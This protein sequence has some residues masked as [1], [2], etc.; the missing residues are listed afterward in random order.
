[1]LQELLNDHIMDPKNPDKIFKL[2]REY[3]RL[4][5]GAMAVSLYLKTADLSDNALLQYKS[6]LGIAKCYWRQGNRTFTVESS[7]LDACGVMP[8]L[9]EAHYFLSLLYAEQQKWK[10]S[11]LHA[12]LGLGKP[13]GCVHSAWNGWGAL[14]PRIRVPFRIHTVKDAFVGVGVMLYPDKLA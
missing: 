8:E 4:E 6:L 11:Y 9:P 1:M 12:R 3:D 2:A 5:Q 13:D 14:L 10:S 7:L